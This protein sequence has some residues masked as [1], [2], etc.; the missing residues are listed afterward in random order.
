MRTFVGRNG[1]YVWRESWLI[2]LQLVLQLI[3]C[4]RRWHDFVLPI[5]GG[6]VVKVKHSCSNFHLEWKMTQVAR[7]GICG[8]QEVI[9]ES[10]M[11]ALLTS[12]NN[13]SLLVIIIIIIQMIIFIIIIICIFII[14]IIKFSNFPQRKEK[15]ATYC[16]GL[17]YWRSNIKS[18]LDLRNFILVYHLIWIRKSEG[19]K[20]NVS[21]LP[22]FGRR[23]V[24][25]YFTFYEVPMV[26]S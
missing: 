4:D 25:R 2:K 10:R 5:T 15:S 1:K 14:V 16:Y 22:T 26:N 11:W 7:L 3:G 12:D 21:L 9:E 20:R 6:T 23:S 19:K 8:N 17:L 24:V 13:N 18:V